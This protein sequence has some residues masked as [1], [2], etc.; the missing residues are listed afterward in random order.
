MS[1]PKGI[2]V[3][4]ASERS[5]YHPE[6]IRRLIRQGK[7]NAELIGLVYFIDPESLQAYVEDMKSANDGRFGPRNG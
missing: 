3:R 6:H 4:E 7:I 1:K 2:T 5:G